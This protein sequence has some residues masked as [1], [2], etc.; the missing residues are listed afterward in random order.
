MRSLSMRAVS[1][2]RLSLR[3]SLAGLFLCVGLSTSSLAVAQSQIAPGQTAAPSPVAEAP[4]APF[5]LEPFSAQY[6]VLRGGRELGEATLSLA[7]LG[8]SRWNV[9]LN[10]RGTGLIGLAGI[11]AEQSTVFEQQAETY[12]PLSQSTVRKALFT[13][14]QITGTY[15]WPHARAQWQGDVKKTRRAPVMLQPGDMSGL[16]INLAIIRDAQPGKSLH[17]RFVDNGRARDHQ[18]LVAP[19]LESVTV[20]DMNYNA[21]R[22]TRAQGGNEETVIWVV[23]GVPTPIRMLQREDGQDTYDLRLT[24]YKGVP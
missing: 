21:M 11:N 7:A 22:V 20:G 6:R 19:E 23:E 14:R 10:M 18:Y 2:R 24:E 16:L 13:R 8:A 17:Y 3:L 15:D 12:R 5:L 1:T 4:A 9:D